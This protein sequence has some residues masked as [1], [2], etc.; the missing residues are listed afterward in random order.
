MKKVFFLAMMVALMATIQ[1]CGN[2]SSQNQDSSHNQG[3]H[4]ASTAGQTHAMLTVQGLCEMCKS[5]I[6]TTA[7]GVNGVSTAMWDQ[8]TKQLHLNFDASKTSLDDVGKA[9]AAVGYDNEKYKAED[10]VYNAL[11]SCCH[12]RQ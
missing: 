12:Y 4:D 8:E 3:M 9:I 10:A 5:K 2:R 1:S 11:P 7:K 6:E